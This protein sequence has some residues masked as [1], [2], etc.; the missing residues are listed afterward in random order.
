MIKIFSY[1]LQQRR[2]NVSLL[3]DIKLTI[4][5]CKLFKR[6]KS[7]FKL[8]NNEQQYL[9]R[10]QVNKVNNIKYLNLLEVSKVEE[11]Q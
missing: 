5:L 6:C 2:K 10:S 9:S 8:L 1:V 3:I 7:T 11:K 4:E